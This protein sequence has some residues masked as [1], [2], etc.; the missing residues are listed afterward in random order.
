MSGRGKVAVHSKDRVR[1]GER[2]AR[3]QQP[4]PA[5][6]AKSESGDCGC[7]CKGKKREERSAAAS[8]TTP[9]SRSKVRAP[10]RAAVATQPGRAASLA[11][12]R[13]QSTR[14][15]AGMSAS[16]MSAAQT[17]RA[18]NPELS[19]RELARALREQRS[20][21]GGAGQKKSEPCG[22]QRPARSKGAAAQDASWKVG[23]SE[24]THGQTVTGTMVGRS[25]SVTGDEPSTCRSVTG[26]EYMG[27]DIFREFCQAEP[28]KGVR[29]VG[30][31]P[32]ARGNSVTG[33]EVGRSLKVTGDEPGT[34]KRVTGTEYVGANQSETFCGTRSEVGPSKISGS[35]TRKGKAVTGNNVGRSGKVTGDEVGAQRQ[36]TGSQYMQLGDNGKAPTK[37]GRSDTLRGGSVTG[38]MIGRREKMTGDEPGSCR[39]VTGDDYIGQEQFKSF[40]NTKPEPKDQKVGISQ[41][42]GGKAVSGTMTG[43]SQRVTGDEPGTCKAITGTPYAGAEQYR[44]HCESDEYFGTDARVR[45]SKRMAGSVM[46]GIQPSVGGTMTGDGKGACETVSGTPYVGADQM[47]G[48]CPATAAEPGSPDFPQALGDAPWGQF[49][50]EAPMHAADAPQATS[51]VT[52]SYYE[53]SGQITG[54]FGKATGRVTGTEEARFGRRDKALNSDIHV[55][56]PMVEG[57]V[58]SRVTG[59]GIEVGSKI[60]GDDWDRGDRVT[61]TEGTS[62]MARNPSLRGGGM[63][64]MAA[65]LAGA[66]ND[67][68]PEPVSKVTGGS[69]NTDKGA[70]ITYSGGARG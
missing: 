5:A 59:E 46:T 9:G 23:A 35:E 55:E 7:G 26:T 52:G 38:T 51:G 33:N 43:R 54:P 64:A 63:N 11:R 18:T 50:V 16:G 42:F 24:T 29:R 36:L 3:V 39:N 30:V 57:R 65:R 53:Q 14:G 1:N 13:A 25:Q 67:D 60:T 12:R 27:A 70:L 48:A 45:P 68:I 32:T 2:R 37:V 69:G 10:R 58:K 34:C 56:A 28:G 6:V 62:A 49:S 20:K 15:K 41:T 8:S 61:G 66:R 17:A 19:G 21:R 4:V 44:N 22:R 47:A 40:C 31:S